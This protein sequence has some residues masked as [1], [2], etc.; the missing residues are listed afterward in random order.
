LLELAG[1]TGMPPQRF[2]VKGSGN[3]DSER[4]GNVFV[5]LEMQIRP[6]RGK[7]VVVADG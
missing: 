2:A 6:H 3:A 1:P 4:E 5:V 7:D